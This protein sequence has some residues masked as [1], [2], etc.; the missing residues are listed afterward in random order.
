[1]FA[2]EPTT[3]EQA[4]GII[5]ATLRYRSITLAVTLAGLIL[6]AFFT[7]A[8]PNDAMAEG[9]LVLTDPRG[10]TVFHDGN[11]FQVDLTRYISERSDF[12]SSGVRARS[13]P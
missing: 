2:S 7:L 3:P 1:M 6:A 12:A 13:C 5:E 9:R 4:P 10:N 8:Q 11:S